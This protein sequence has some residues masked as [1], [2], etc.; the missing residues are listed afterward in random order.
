MKIVTNSKDCFRKPH[1]NFFPASFY[2]NVDYL[3]CTVRVHV[4]VG[5]RNYIQDHTR[6]PEPGTIVRV[7]GDE[8]RNKTRQEG[9]STGFSELESVFIEVSKNF[10][11]DFSTKR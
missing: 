10:I 11:F 8:S 6:L 5:F 1:E 4:I 2:V 9:F 3:Q 7:M